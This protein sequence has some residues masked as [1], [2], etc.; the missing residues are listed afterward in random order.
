MFGMEDAFALFGRYI[1][2]ACWLSRLISFE[3]C[4]AATRG[5][6]QE[7]VSRVE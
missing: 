2:E 1:Q 3:N 5:I 6:V 4:E 7:S